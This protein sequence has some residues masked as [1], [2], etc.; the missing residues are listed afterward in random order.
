MLYPLGDSIGSVEL[1]RVSG[2]SKDVVNAARV[3]FG[4]DEIGGKFT[5]K[6]YRLLKY[7]LRHEHGSPFEHTLLQFRI[8]APLFVHIHFLKHRAGVSI[9]AQSGRYV[10][11]EEVAYIPVSFR[12]QSPTNKQG[13]VNEPVEEQ[14]KAQSIFRTTVAQA[15]EAYY[16]LLK[17]G[18]CKEQARAVLPQTIY[19]SFLVTCNVRSLLHFLHLREAGGAQWETR[20]YAKAIRQLSEPAFPEIFSVLSELKATT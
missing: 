1:L 12:Q 2:N 14:T 5:D 9:N 17:I 10:E 13:S 4:N 11:I 19:T 16:D 15:Y 3:S 6:D 18:V 7:L 20:Q 8:V